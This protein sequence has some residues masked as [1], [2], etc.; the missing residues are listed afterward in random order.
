[1]LSLGIVGNGQRG[2]ETAVARLGGLD[3]VGAVG[4]G[5]YAIGIGAQCVALLGDGVL[6]AVDIGLEV[7]DEV[8][9]LGDGDTHLGKLTEIGLVSN[10]SEVWRTALVLTNV[11]MG[12]DGVTE[13]VDLHY[14][15]VH[16]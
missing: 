14:A 12:T 10:G 9:C 5:I 4:G 7:D 16:D 15:L 6:Y 11:A 2:A 1:M 8:L 3:D 13:S